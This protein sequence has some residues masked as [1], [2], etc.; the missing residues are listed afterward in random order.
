MQTA[1]HQMRICL[2]AALF[3]LASCLPAHLFAQSA[4]ISGQVLDATGAAVKGASV[5]LVRPSTQVRVTAVTDAKG[6]YILPP[7]APGNYEATVTAPGFAAWKET[8]VVVE[9]GQQMAI[10]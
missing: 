4:S 3:L 7:V 8:N 2:C 10:N 5:T 6:I 1:Q 9:I